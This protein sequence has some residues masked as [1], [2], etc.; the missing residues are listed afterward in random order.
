MVEAGGALFFAVMMVWLLDS[1]RDA[2]RDKLRDADRDV[3]RDAERDKLRDVEGY[4]VLWL[5]S[6]EYRKAGI[7]DLYN[8][9][10]GNAE[11]AL[12]KAFEDHQS[13]EVLLAGASLRLFLAPGQ[14]FYGY[15]KGMVGRGVG[16]TDRLPITVRALS[17]SPEHNRELPVRSF[18]EEFN[19]DGSFPKKRHFDWRQ[20][21]DFDFREF[22]ETFYEKHGIRSPS[23]QKLRVITDL[24]STRAGVKELQG[25]ATSVSNHLFHGEFDSAPYCTVIIFPD[26]AFYTPNILSSEVPANLPMIVFHKSS[27]A[28]EKLVDYVE[29]LWWLGGQQN[30]VE[31][32]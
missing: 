24:E 5:F 1:M 15:V 27:E 21:K 30:E 7:L 10:R 4:S 13:G 32:V 26:R 11:R 18:A 14:H 3:L 31:D 6:E 28:Y 16:R 12:E 9:R 17:C 22:E 25:I 20:P 23:S 29:F 19:Q 2:E 8:D